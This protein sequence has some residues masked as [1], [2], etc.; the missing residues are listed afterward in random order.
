MQGGQLLFNDAG[1]SFRTQNPMG[2]LFSACFRHGFQISAQPILPRG[3]GALA[4]GGLSNK[5]NF[6]VAK[7]EQ[8]RCCQVA[9]RLMVYQDAI[10]GRAGWMKVK[11]HHRHAGPNEI[12]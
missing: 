10:K 6:S 5:G 9:C 7:R 4:I 11:R 8:V 3:I 2:R 1:I 12:V